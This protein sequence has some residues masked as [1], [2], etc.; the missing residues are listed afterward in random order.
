MRLHWWLLAL[1]VTLAALTVVSAQSASL[2]PELQKALDSSKY[3]YIQSTRKDGKLSKPAEIWFMPYNGAVWVASPPTTYR[4]KRIQA[5]Q[6][7]AKIAIG[8]TDGPSF[9]A[10][11]SI[12]KDPEVNKVLFEVFA[13][14]YGSGWSSLEEK[15]RDGLADGSRVLVKYEPAD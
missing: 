9:N 6:T 2:S 14:K 15:F 10:K 7:K 3:V 4:V 8:K 12:V 1:I 11:G 13:K 5:G